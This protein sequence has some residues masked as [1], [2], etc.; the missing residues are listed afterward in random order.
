MR[1]IIPTLKA[2]NVARVWPQTMQVFV[3]HQIDLRAGGD[4]ALRDVAERNHLNL[5]QFLREINDAIDRAPA[6][7]A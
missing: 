5:E 1:F 7:V 3:Q 2:S 4:G 6:R